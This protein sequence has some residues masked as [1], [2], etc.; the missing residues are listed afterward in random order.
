MDG[1]LTKIGMCK[2][3]LPGPTAS[4]MKAASGVASE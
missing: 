1:F 4:L 3:I 2:E